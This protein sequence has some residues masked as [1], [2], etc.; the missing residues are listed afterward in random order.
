M[1][2]EL[3]FAAV[4][5]YDRTGPL[6]DRFVEPSGVSIRA[7]REHPVD[8]FRQL[9][10]GETFDIAEMSLSTLL[11][12]TSRDDHRFVALP[13]F[14]SRQFRHGAIVVRQDA[15]I[16][17]PEDLAGRRVGMS[18]YQMTAA[19]WVRAILSDEYGVAPSSITWF[20]GGFNSYE[21]PR[22]DLPL[23]PEFSLTRI[24][25]DT[26]LNALLE[27]GELDATID[28]RLPDC[29]FKP[30][31]RVGRL[32]E[33]YKSLERDYFTRTRLFPIMHTV[34]LRRELLDRHR[35]LAASL[36]E[37]FSRALDAGL[38]RVRDS[39]NF[40]VSLPWLSAAADEAEDL[41]LF[42]AWGYGIANNRHVLEYMC[43]KSYE[44]AL[45]V[46]RVD[47]SEVFAASLLDT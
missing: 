33:D 4:H 21:P 10:Q 5:N 45:S 20:E 31:S 29:M 12:L 26:T 41:G 47:I 42:A 27:A 23:R 6:L 30:D 46:R 34:V 14:P 8:L 43:D 18:E 35:W 40:A 9:A 15:G 19:L 7:F 44:Q 1:S 36:Y 24:P 25:D 37:A 13:V 22:V 16:T 39:L 17:R 11:A 28:S 32:F 38:K 2:L 3:S